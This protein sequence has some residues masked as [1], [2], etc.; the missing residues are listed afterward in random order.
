MSNFVATRLAAI[1]GVEKMLQTDREQR[2]RESKYRA[3][4]NSV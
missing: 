1:V 4:S 3:H 2:I